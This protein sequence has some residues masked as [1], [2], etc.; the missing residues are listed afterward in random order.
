M[1]QKVDISQIQGPD[2]PTGCYTLKYCCATN[3]FSWSDDKEPWFYQGSNYGFAFGGFPSV[4][5]MIDKFCFADETIGNCV[6]CLAVNAPRA[7]RKA[8]GITSGVFGY[9]A[10]GISDETAIEK[11]PFV[12]VGN[13]TCIGSL[14]IGA[15]GGAPAGHATENDGFTSSGAYIDAIQ[16]FPFASDDNATCVG[17][18]SIAWF[19][20]GGNSSTTDGYSVAGYNP[21]DPS[22][23][24]LSNSIQKF[25]FASATTSTCVG[26]GGSSGS[27]TGA[28]IS[29]ATD[30]YHYGQGCIFKWPFASDTPTT[31]FGPVGL[32]KNFRAGASATEYGYG[33]GGNPASTNIYRFSYASDTGVTCVATLPSNSAAFVMGTHY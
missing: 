7:D 8:A 5:A 19:Y 29:S 3:K 18:L 24:P 23:F 16:K 20:A 2:D 17:G 26:V 21:G 12:S 13:S 28:G 9:T 15:P 33:F 6:G 1:A 31:C 4:N 14:A 22:V 25:P 30:G 27:F 10:G 32:S 11:W